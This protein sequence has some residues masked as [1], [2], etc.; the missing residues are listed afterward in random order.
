MIL[1]FDTETTGKLDFKAGPEAAQQPNL[2]QLACML[3]AEGGQVI[4]QLNCI[5]QPNGWEISPE[6]ALIHGIT[7]ERAK[8][9]G[10]PMLSCLSVFSHFCKVAKKLVAYNL[11]FDD[12]I[13]QVAYHRA[14][15][16]HR[17]DHLKKICAMRAS[18][19]ICKLPKPSGWRSKPG[20][21]Y[22]WP[23][24]AEAYAH[25]FEGKTFDGAHDAM[26]DVIALIKVYWELR[27]IGA[28]L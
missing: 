10:I 2:V 13:M 11:D 4:G 7:N 20:D 15:K 26:N 9:A 28:I 23:S 6:V 14:G 16:P 24:L 27:K 18:T 25:F 22:K 8:S 21:E 12:V 1:F 5:I 17:M 19:P 3:M